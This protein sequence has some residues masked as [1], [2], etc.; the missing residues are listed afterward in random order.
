MYQFV[1]AI[2]LLSGVKIGKNNS[3]L[4]NNQVFY[5]KIDKLT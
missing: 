1:A 5:K 3:N 4:F 2:H